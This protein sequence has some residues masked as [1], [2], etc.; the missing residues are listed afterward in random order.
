[1]ELLGFTPDLPVETPGTLADVMGMVPSAKGLKSAPSPITVATLAATCMG[2]ASL[3]KLDN[4]SRTFA[5]TNSALYELS[6]GSWTSVGHTTYSAGS[7]D[8][9]SFAQYGD[10]SLVSSKEVRL[11][12]SSTGNF[13]YV[14]SAPSASILCIAQNFVFAFN[15]KDGTAGTSFG[16]SPD[17]WW[18]SALGS[19]TDWS[20]AIATQSASG[21]LTQT[22]GAI[23]AG[24]MLGDLVVAYK[25]R[26]VYV[27]VYQGAPEIWRFTEVANF[28]GAVSNEVV[29]PIA[30]ANGGFMHLFMGQDDFYRFDGSRPAAIPN[31]LKEWVFQRLDQAN[32]YKSFAVHDIRNSVVRWYFP[33]GSTVGTCVAFNYKTGRWGRDDRTVQFGFEF[34]QPG[35]SYDSLGTSY[36]TYDAFPASSY[37]Q[38]FAG[39]QVR[40]PAIFNSSNVLQTLTGTGGS[41]SFTTGV[42]GSEDV[43]SS[44]TRVRCRYQSAPTSP[45]L[46]NYYSN[47]LGT[48]YTADQNVV[49]DGS[50]FDLIRSAKWHRF[51]VSG[52]G[53]MEISDFTPIMSL[54]GDE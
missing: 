6:S 20:P 37:D 36:S 5:A 51:T 13:A 16:D 54:D 11:Q 48:G 7:T 22:P 17:R 47:Q 9:W 52:T 45:Q 27:G 42:F 23:T 24:K 10:V 29:V 28:C 21:R 18:C 44:V 43:Y 33:T 4:T 25:S 49:G 14:T 38:A 3:V 8:R 32:A 30:L 34:I 50:K 2:A 53:D 39:S 1:M 26:A 40:Q 46:T 12:Q 15:T 41:W 35:I 19:Y 31:N